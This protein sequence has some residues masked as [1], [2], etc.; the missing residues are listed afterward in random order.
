MLPRLGVPLML[1]VGLSLLLPE[2]LRDGVHRNE[3]VHESVGS[4]DCVR[5]AVPVCET[6][7]EQ[8]REGGDADREDGV[9]TAV[10]VGVTLPD[11][12]TVAAPV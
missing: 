5:L 6:V 2:M 8:V 1:Q 12:D 11:D 4:A 10:V 3:A 9:G 7:R